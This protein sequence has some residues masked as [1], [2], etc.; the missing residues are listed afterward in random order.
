MKIAVYIL[1]IPK[2]NFI[3]S[4]TVS[5]HYSV[6]PVFFCLPQ[7]LF[8]ASCCFPLVQVQHTHSVFSAIKL[9]YCTAW[10]TCCLLNKKASCSLK[11]K[12]KFFFF[13]LIIHIFLSSSEILAHPLLWTCYPLQVQTLLALIKKEKVWQ[14]MKVPGE[15][16]SLIQLVDC[17]V[18]QFHIRSSSEG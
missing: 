17:P 11:R 4:L 15:S 14:Q 7:L 16:G 3:Q 13:F 6:L 8:F 10:L 1:L 9:W 2:F 18:L 12:T 5:F